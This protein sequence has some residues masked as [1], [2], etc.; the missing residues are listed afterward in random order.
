MTRTRTYDGSVPTLRVRVWSQVLSIP[1]GYEEGGRAKV[2]ATQATAQ[3]AQWCV[4]Y[5]H[6]C[7]SQG[8]HGMHRRAM[9]M[10]VVVVVYGGRG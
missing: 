7:T 5:R 1:M 3:C 6:F 2:R 10:I 8:G 4:L 9:V